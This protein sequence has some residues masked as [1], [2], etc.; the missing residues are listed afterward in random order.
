MARVLLNLPKSA[1]PG[2]VVTVKLLISHPM[3]S[4]QRHDEGGS[5]VPQNVINDL[6]CRYDGAEV[7]RL[8]LHPAIAANPFF[9]FSFR[10]DKPGTLAIS[11]VDD[12]GVAGFIQRDLE[13]G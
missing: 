12:Q 11:W 2:E 4:G 13:V 6:R 5:L 8:T 7:L 3:E 1:K 10:A 9:Q